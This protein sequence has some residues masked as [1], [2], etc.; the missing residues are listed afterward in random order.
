M[1]YTYH[2]KLLLPLVLILLLT[3]GF[4]YAGDSK[5]IYGEK[6]PVTSEAEARQQL[7]EFFNDQ[8]GE[9]K[10]ITEQEFFYEAEFL[11]TDGKV[12]DRVIVDKRTG[13]IRSIH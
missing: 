10:N 5:N 13:R 7:T 11:S 4:G 3:P 12:I 1:K 2:M 6:H 9:L 8:K